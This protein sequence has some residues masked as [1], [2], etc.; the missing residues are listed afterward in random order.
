MRVSLRII[1]LLI[2]LLLV[3]AAIILWG[4]ALAGEN[5]ARNSLQVLIEPATPLVEPVT[6]E[7]SADRGWQNTG[8]LLRPG[9]TIHIQF[10][11]GEIRDGEAVIRGPTGVG[12]AC[13]D[14]S[15]CEPMPNADRDA[16]IGRVGDFL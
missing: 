11:S 16:V 8:I 12:W 15:C 2:T 10:V 3:I 1:G 4:A 6:K 9:E 5:S 14:S 7:I 13:G